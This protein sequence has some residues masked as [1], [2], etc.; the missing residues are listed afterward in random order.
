MSNSKAALG[1]LA[2]AA[3]GAILGILFA[4]DSGTETRRKISKK[5]SD[6]SDSLKNSFNDFVDGLKQT[7]TSAREEA[8]EMMESGKAKMNTYKNE[9]KNTMS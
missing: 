5:T 3:A 9:T 4:P 2:G 6:V 1:F 7:Y 8:E